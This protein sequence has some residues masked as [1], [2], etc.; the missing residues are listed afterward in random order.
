MSIEFKVS[1]VIP[2]A[3][4]EVYD[5]W[6]DSDG[7]TAMTGSPAHATAK[8]GGTF[9]AW[10][11]YISGTNL[12]FGPGLRIVQAWRTQQFEEQHES[13]RIEVTFEEAAGGTHVTIHHTDVPDGQPDYGQGWVDHYLEPM[14]RHYG[15]G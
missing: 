8:V 14:K 5:A 4:Q 11:G 1:D 12:E 6:L 7:H 2:A 3:P 13:S 15:G 9:D 10:D